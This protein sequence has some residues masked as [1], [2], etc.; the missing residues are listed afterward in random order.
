VP[1]K[2]SE[3]QGVRSRGTKQDSWARVRHAI[4]TASE[5][6]QVSPLEAR[7]FA[8]EVAAQL[9]PDAPPSISTLFR[10]LRAERCRRALDPS[11][12]AARRTES[13]PKITRQRAG[14]EL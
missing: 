8:G 7:R 10:S 5:H 14:L 2:T 4:V 3:A 11:I 9:P 13:S 6:R 1:F 12:R